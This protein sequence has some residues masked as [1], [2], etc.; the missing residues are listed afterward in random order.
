MK[1]PIT[2]LSKSPF[3]SKEEEEVELIELNKW[4]KQSK[5]ADIDALINAIKKHLALSD[6]IKGN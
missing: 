3:S 6:K 4:I 1:K 5:Q 2:Y